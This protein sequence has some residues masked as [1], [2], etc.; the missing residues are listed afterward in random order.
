MRIEAKI[1]AK[2]TIVTTITGPSQAGGGSGL[3]P[4][5]AGPASISTRSAAAIG[6]TTVRRIRIVSLPE[7]SDTQTTEVRAERFR[8]G[9]SFDSGGTFGS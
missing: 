5:D 8:A 1:A 6:T 9:M 3:P 4:A 7:S 2:K